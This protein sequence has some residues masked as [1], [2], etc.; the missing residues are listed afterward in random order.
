MFQM[1]GV[2]SQWKF[3]ILLPLTHLV[4]GVPFLHGL[5]L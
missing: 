4:C 3:G 1:G 2:V 5:L